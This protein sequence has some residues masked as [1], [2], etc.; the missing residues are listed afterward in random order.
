MTTTEAFKNVT[1]KKLKR[2]KQKK[3]TNNKSQSIKATVKFAT[4]PQNKLESDVERFTTHVQI[5]LATKEVVSS[6]VQ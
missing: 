3:N 5:C 4:L 1:F 2:Y 6:C